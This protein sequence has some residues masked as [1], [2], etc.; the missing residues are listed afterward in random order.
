MP[1][2]ESKYEAFLEHLAM[3][4]VVEIA[5]ERA[6]I[7]KDTIYTRARKDWQFR[8]RFEQARKDGAKLCLVEQATDLSI[9]GARRLRFNPKTGA[10]YIDPKTGEPYE[11]RE[12][13][14]QL[15]MFMLRAADPETYGDA[16]RHEIGRKSD[17]D[18]LEMLASDKTVL[19]DIVGRAV[20]A[21]H[22]RVAGPDITVFGRRIACETQ[23][24]IE[25]PSEEAG[26]D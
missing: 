15:L 10:P 6:G 2:D 5:C 26:T 11:E 12:Y 20:S 13:Q 14:P 18:L 3:C 25:G 7:N 23:A 1:Y 9:N 8:E 4:A 21:G 19:V 22:I 16:V 24:P 17:D